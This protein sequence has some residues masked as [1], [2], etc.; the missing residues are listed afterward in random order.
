MM[1]FRRASFIL[2]QIT[3]ILIFPGGLHNYNL[4]YLNWTYLTNPIT[5]QVIYCLGNTDDC[6]QER[7]AVQN[8]ATT[9]NASGAAFAFPQIQEGPGGGFIEPTR[10]GQN[11]I[12][13]MTPWPAKYGSRGAVTIAWCYAGSSNILEV[14][15]VFN[16]DLTWS[17]GSTPPA[18][19]RVLRTDEDGAIEI[20]V[21]APD[22]AIRTAHQKDPGH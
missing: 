20:S 19:A 11:Q 22:L 5:S 2:W 1:R 3:V 14:D 18:G 12:G 6:T 15:T 16:D 7:A 13:W 21:H 4:T 9:W 10:D 8:A 17:T